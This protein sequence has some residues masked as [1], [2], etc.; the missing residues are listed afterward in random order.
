MNTTIITH[1]NDEW[2][3]NCGNTSYADGF[4][5]SD[6]QGVEVEPV[7]GWGGLYVCARCQS[8]HAMKDNA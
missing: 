7:A 6:E 5:P 1:D 3:C 4:Y 2:T 8:L